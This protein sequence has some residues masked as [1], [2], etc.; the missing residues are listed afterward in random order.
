MENPNE[1]KQFKKIYQIIDY[2]ICD[3]G[4]WNENVVITSRG[5]GLLS[6]SSTNDL[7]NLMGQNQQWLSPY[8]CLYHHPKNGFIVLDVNI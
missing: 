1:M 5:T 3:I 2:R 4:W 7:T 8:A 6:L